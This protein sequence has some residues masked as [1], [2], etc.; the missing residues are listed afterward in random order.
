MYPRKYH[1]QQALNGSALG[2][3][4]LEWACNNREAG[5]L[6]AVEQSERPWLILLTAMSA[7]SAVLLA[8]VFW[9]LH[10]FH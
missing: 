4:Y 3:R 10:G 6:Q 8:L 1:L 2:G 9:K 7:L 5:G